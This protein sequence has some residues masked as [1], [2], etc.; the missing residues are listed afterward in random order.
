M[1]EII[2]QRELKQFRNL[3]EEARRLIAG[4]EALGKDLIS[5]IQGGA[6]VEPGNLVPQLQENSSQRFSFDALVAIMGLKQT[7]KLKAQLPTSV[8]YSV[9]IVEAA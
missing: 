1:T 9:K 2:L 5:R 4:K 3:S 8:S 7:E 6:E